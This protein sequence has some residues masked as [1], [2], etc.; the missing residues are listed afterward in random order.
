MSE[1]NTA[2]QTKQPSAKAV[3]VSNIKSLVENNYYKQLFKQSL[4]ANA[5][6]FT[7]SIMEVI[8]NDAN[9]IKCEPKALMQEC[10]KAASLKLPINKQLGYAYLVPYNN[11]PTL[12]IGY[13]GYIQLAIRS[14]QYR[15]I[16][17]DIVY[18]G[19]L[20]GYDKL[21]GLID[22]TGKRESDKVVGYFA[23]FELLNGFK[24]TLYMSL[25]KMAK[26]AVRY[27]LTL[28]KRNPEELMKLAQEQSDNGIA[29]NGIGWLGDINSMACKTT[30]RN[31]LGKYGYLSTEMQEAYEHEINIEANALHQRDELNAAPKPT[32][33]VSQFTEAEEVADDEPSPF[34]QK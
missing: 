9:L 29:G 1:T 5:G 30:L 12:I 23:Y 33:D 28:K 11:I 4:G 7:T 10:V 18:E 8:T 27:V 15:G 21:T 13:K 31:I 3:A 14:G 6:A 34:D 32:F 25:E 22:L 16:N 26:Y 20:R 17:T 2:V 19:E 24:K